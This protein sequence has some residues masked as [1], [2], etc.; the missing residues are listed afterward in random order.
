MSKLSRNAN[1]DDMVRTTRTVFVTTKTAMGKPLLQAERNAN[2][3]IDVLRTNV[4]AKKL[5]VHDFLIMPDHVH[6]LLSITE[7]TIEKAM[8]LIKG[9]F[10]YRLKKDFGF[11]GEVWQRGFADDRIN[12]GESFAQ[13]REYIRQNPVRAGLTASPEE[14]PF[15]FTYLARQKVAGAKARGLE[16]LSGTTEVL[17]FHES[18]GSESEV[19]S[20]HESGSTSSHD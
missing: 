18:A 13:H 11:D 3:L 19:L 2:L 8:Q 14:F 17:P 5:R 9:G 10:S 16:A 1:P 6:L 7:M 4:A 20:T 15:C 12:D